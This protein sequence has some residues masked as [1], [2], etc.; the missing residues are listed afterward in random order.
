MPAAKSCSMAARCSS[1]P[2]SRSW[3]GDHDRAQQ[4]YDESIEVHRRAGEVWGLSILLVGCGGAAHRSAG[5]RPG[6]RAGLRGDVALSGARRST[7]DCLESRRVRGAAGRRRTRRR[8]G[9]V[10]G[11]LRRTAGKRGRLAGADDRVDPG[12]LLRARE[13]HRSGAQH[14]RPPAP[15][16][17]RCRSS[18]RLRSRVSR[19]FSAEFLHVL[20]QRVCGSLDTYRRWLSIA[21]GGRLTSKTQTVRRIRQPR[22][23]IQFASANRLF[24]SNSRCFAPPSSAHV[25]HARCTRLETTRAC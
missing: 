1:W 13:E 2:T 21:V 25:S 20:H 7:R 23:K 10:V 12:S 24:G 6:A 15:R 16:G 17:A 9:P 22:A 5:L 3:S 11:C 19:R 14:S 18:R 4:L 8:S